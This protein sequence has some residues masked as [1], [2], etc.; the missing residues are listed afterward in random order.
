MMLVQ[1]KFVLDILLGRDVSWNA[2]QRQ[3]SVISFGD[4]AKAHIGHTVAGLALLYLTFAI[5]PHTIAWLSPIW[6]GLC[7]SIPL[8]FASS[9][10]IPLRLKPMSEF[11]GA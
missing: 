4:V 7:L 9:A 3:S 5:S 10:P 6:L 2:Q 1:S 11:W 8:I